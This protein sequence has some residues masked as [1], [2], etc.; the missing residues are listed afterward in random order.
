M[1]FT[2]SQLCGL[3]RDTPHPFGGRCSPLFFCK[4]LDHCL[5][6]IQCWPPSESQGNVRQHFT[7]KQPELLLSLC[8]WLLALSSTE[9]SM[10]RANKKEERE[11]VIFSPSEQ[12]RP[13]DRSSVTSLVGWCCPRN[14]KGPIN[15]HRRCSW[16]R[17]SLRVI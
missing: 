15:S 7:L 10:G 8:A 3:G 4:G 14:S 9:T 2:R 11:L 1:K 16:F 6:L 5:L 13:G 17:T 12:K